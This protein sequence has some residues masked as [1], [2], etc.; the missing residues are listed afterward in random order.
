MSDCWDVCTILTGID[1][2]QRATRAVCNADRWPSEA[3]N[4]HVAAIWALLDFHQV[5]ALIECC[6]FHVITEC[7]FPL[8]IE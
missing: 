6:C 8:Y 5:R 2:I 3:L 4:K 7:V 1:D